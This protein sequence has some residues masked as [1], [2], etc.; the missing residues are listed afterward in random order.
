M[1]DS[2]LFSGLKHRIIDWA[3]TRDDIRLVILVGSRARTE[4]PGSKYA[5][6]DILLFTDQRDG[7][8]ADRTWMK[9]FGE[10]LVCIEGRTAGDDPELMAIYKGFQGIDFVFIPATAIRGLE[11]L[12]E[13]PEIFSRGYSIWL[14]KEEVTRKIAE[15]M[16]KRKAL[17]RHQKP[18]EA[19]FQNAL[20]SFLFGTYY[21]ARV[22]FQQDLWPA[23]ARE[24]DLR[25]RVLQM[26]EWHACATHD[27]TWDVWHMGKYMESWAD[28]RVLES[29]PELYSGYSVKQSRQALLR[30]FELFEMLARETALLTGFA[31]P[32]I[33]FE[34]IKEFVLLTMET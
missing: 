20:S 14:D 10:L 23:K 1:S 25:R 9:N 31:F 4:N 5:D 3:A 2:K 30:T 28:P 34:E 18:D 15:R 21:V 26:I 6:L 19:A 24:S 7:Y 16:P 29:L 33:M 8:L 22:L 32:D 12:A 11:A 27:W 13:L 17:P